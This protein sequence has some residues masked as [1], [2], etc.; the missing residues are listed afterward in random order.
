MGRPCRVT[1]L[2]LTRNVTPS[3]VTGVQKLR[4]RS[5][6]KLRV[7]RVNEQD[8]ETFNEMTK[9]VHEKSAHVFLTRLLKHSNLLIMYISQIMYQQSY[10][11]ECIFTHYIFE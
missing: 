1:T 2:L 8:T 11:Y 10:L 5:G 4:L 6:S 9:C 3:L 7:V